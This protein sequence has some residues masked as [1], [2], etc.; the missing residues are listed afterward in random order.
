M[1]EQPSNKRH[2]VNQPESPSS[3]LPPAALASPTAGLSDAANEMTDSVLAPLSV[4]PP[5]VPA[6]GPRRLFP[7]VQLQVRLSVQADGTVATHLHVRQSSKSARREERRDRK[8]ELLHANRQSKRRQDKQRRREQ[9]RAAQQQ[10]ESESQPATALPAVRRGKL[11]REWVRSR[12]SSSPVVCIDC[13]WESA[14][15]ETEVQSLSKQVKFLYAD[16]MHAQHPLRIQLTSYGQLP[17]EKPTAALTAEGA[18][19]EGRVEAESVTSLQ[20]PRLCKYMAR[21]EGF[22]RWLMERSPLH[23]RDVF[24]SS[25]VSCA[26]TPPSV[27]YLTAE[28]PNLLT[29]LEPH[30]V[31]VI[32][33]LVDHNRLPGLC[34]SAA[35]AVGMATARLPITECMRIENGS[36]RTVITVNQVFDC[37]L[38]WWNMDMERSGQSSSSSSSSSGQSQRQQCSDEEAWQL[39]WAAAFDSALPKRGGWQVR[40][41]WSAALTRSDELVRQSDIPQDDDA[42]CDSTAPIKTP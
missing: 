2:K 19:H 24:A 20:A 41:E 31:Y 40:E 9:R 26:T 32:G 30:A 6:V 11:F 3:S 8:F 28:S 37:L 42:D 18:A 4:P 38:R 15:V 27:T 39:R 29:R 10:T 34:H 23:Y 7:N 25:R 36:R 21:I 14:M 13:Q 17:A 33:A 5:A 12:Q 1:N 16:N 22:D 35:L